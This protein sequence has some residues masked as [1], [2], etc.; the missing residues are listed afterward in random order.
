MSRIVILFL[1]LLGFSVSAF[2]QNDFTK[3]MSEVKR[4][5][6]KSVPLDASVYD[7]SNEAS[8][9]LDI[10]LNKK[11]KI[12]NTTIFCEDS[13]TH[14][15][16]IRM[17][18]QK[19]ETEWKP[20]KTTFRR[21]LIPVLLIISA[22]DDADEVLNELPLTVPKGQEKLTYLSKEIVIMP[23]FPMR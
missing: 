23:T 17:A 18:L 5:I 2:S 3:R 10:Q 1:G 20:V 8:F 22:K 16:F 14:T 4:I 9:I 21:I 19:I 12:Q 7:N 13:S 6:Q 11:G 15:R